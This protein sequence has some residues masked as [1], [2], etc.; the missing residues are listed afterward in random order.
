M[1]PV[2]RTLKHVF[3]KLRRHCPVMPSTGIQYKERQ[4]V[5]RFIHAWTINVVVVEIL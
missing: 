5:N 4:Q 2:S 1:T 3:F